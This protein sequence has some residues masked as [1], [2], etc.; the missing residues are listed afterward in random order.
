MFCVEDYFDY[1]DFKCVLTTM[2]YGGKAPSCDVS[3]N[4][5]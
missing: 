4:C 5:K 2:F 3:E 1:F